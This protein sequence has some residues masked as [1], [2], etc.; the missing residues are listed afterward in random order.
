MTSNNLE[1]SIFM[2]FTG[3]LRRNI[4]DRCCGLLFDWQSRATSVL[5]AIGGQEIATA[6]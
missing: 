1:L 2:R 4:M 6:G 5:V 3:S